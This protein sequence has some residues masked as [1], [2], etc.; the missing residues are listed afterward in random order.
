MAENTVPAAELIDVLGE[1]HLEAQ[2]AQEHVAS[3][4]KAVEALTHLKDSP[5][6]ECVAAILGEIRCF[7]ETLANEID[8]ELGRAE[9]KFLK[10]AEPV[11]KPL[12]GGNVHD[13]A[14]Y[15]QRDTV[16]VL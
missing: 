9:R 15:R 6:S 7:V 2:Y 4:C 16:A 11:A 5:K 12:L 8:L 13:L 3:L 10:A 1:L 14:A